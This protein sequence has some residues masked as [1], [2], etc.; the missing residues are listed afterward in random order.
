MYNDADYFYYSDTYDLTNS[1][2]R[3]NADSY[4][5][6]KPLWERADERF[7]WNKSMLEEIMEVKVRGLSGWLFSSMSFSWLE[8]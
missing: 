5:K 6:E 3:Q 2:Q 4:N 1:L 7:F 8:C